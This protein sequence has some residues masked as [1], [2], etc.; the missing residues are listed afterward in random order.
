[1]KK[2]LVALLSLG[3][4]APAVVF[5]AIT[6]LNGGI[7]GIKLS[8]QVNGSYFSGPTASP[9][10]AYELSATHLKGNRVYASGSGDQKIY[11]M[12][13]ATDPC[14]AAD[15]IDSFA[16]GGIFASIATGTDGTTWT[17]L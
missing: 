17:A 6:N 9:G 12:K 10:A 4:F 3:L 8:N 5:A 13:C 1:M 15:N 16:T 11:Y 2:I 14:T 7:A